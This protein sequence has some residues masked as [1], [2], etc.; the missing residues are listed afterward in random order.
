MPPEHQPSP[1]S[2]AP[3][4][5]S[6]RSFRLLVEC[7]EDYAILL[8]D[9][10]GVITSWN[11]GVARLTGFH[12]DEI[13]GRHFSCLLPSEAIER[14][15]PAAALDAAARDGRFENEGWRIR[16][17]GTR[18]WANVI[19]TALRGSDGA[20]LG[21]AKVTRD[22][23]LRR[24][25]E[26]AIRELNAELDRRL[27]E[28]SVE[29]SHEH[30][31]FKKELA[32]RKR[33]ERE[34]ER[35]F[36]MSLD[37]ICIAGLDGYFIKLNPAWEKALGFS[38]EELRARPFMDFIHPDDRAATLAEI[39]KMDAGVDII[40]FENRYR[41]KDGSYRWLAWQAPATPPGQDYLYATARDVTEP[42]QAKARIA[43]LLERLNLATR[44][45]HLGIWDWD[46]VRNELVWDDRM[47]EL[48]GVRKENFGGAYDAW[49]KGVHPDDR[50]FCDSE[51]QRALSGE[52]DYDIDFR[53]LWPDGTLRVIKAD[54]QIVRD[55]AGTPLRMTGINYDITDHKRADQRV[56]LQ[57]AVSGVLAES[58][59]LEEATPRLVGAIAQAVNARVGAIWRV[60][61]AVEAL[62]CISVWH[63]PGLEVADFEAKSREITFATGIGLPGRVW[64]THKPLR[65]PDITADS[66]FPRAAVASAAGLHAAFAVPILSG[67]TC[68]GVI[69]FFSHEVHE[70]DTELI[71]V[72][73][74]IGS[75]V[76]Q[77]T[78]RKRAE[79]TLTRLNA[80]ATER[81]AQL[82]A[83]NKELEAFS[84]S[85]SHDLRAPL[86][87]VQ[88][89][90]EL[91]KKAAGDQLSEK[92]RGH[93]KVISDASRQMG[94]LIDD[95]LAF[96]RIGRTEMIRVA[97]N[98]DEL[99][100]L[101]LRSLEFE[102]RDR[103]IVWK[104]APLP[105]VNGDR[106]MLRQVFANLMGNAV[107]YT[108]PR[109]PAE[110]EIGSAGREDG[111]VILFIKDNGVGFDMQYANKL[112]GVFHRLHTSEE[113]EGTGIGLA[114]VRR[115]ITRHGGRIWPEAALDKGATF[116]F[117]LEEAAAHRPCFRAA[118]A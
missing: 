12:R 92:A 70:P 33:A 41:H 18:F 59:T 37:M 98:L 116:F 7:V 29:L 51:I 17:D 63:Q 83:A 11:P 81:A 79:E 3:A 61:S 54:S 49:L 26:E 114:N 100:Q 27:R 31:S 97:V 77:F 4:L 106:S 28:Q 60:D 107:K 96:S 102:T 46:I 118:R 14:K 101:C 19:I 39:R 9:P 13:L 52:K 16:K 104:I 78:E 24:K 93:L 76:G 22:L 91:L 74:G 38:R 87:H 40:H 6:D 30:E 105:A 75:Q 117:T 71:K 55:A 57:L 42:K 65:I 43:S 72:C 111:Q 113:F 109:D 84:Y 90:V 62:R 66:N 88:G 58:A 95:L 68:L 67:E 45:A 34:M 110:I 25:N 69:E 44:A 82:E 108:G 47:Y 50:A 48:Y 5:G 10:H 36:E 21:F 23:T 94:Q 73:R 1:G 15:L 32:G 86:R 64:Q 99:V 115:I 2:Q 85:V 112:F 80:E 56:A 89:Y 8:L 20:I 53:V 103:R 35:F